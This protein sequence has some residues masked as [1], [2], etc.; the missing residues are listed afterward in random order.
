MKNCRL[1][2]QFPLGTFFCPFPFFEQNSSLPATLLS[3]NFWL[4]RLMGEGFGAFFRVL[5]PL[6]RPLLPIRGPFGLIS[7][8]ALR[9][10]APFSRNQ[11]ALPA[12][13]GFFFAKA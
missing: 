13:K 2:F 8:A 6:W 3:R 1:F 10:R 11:T 7:P 9:S 5:S 12:F 4:Q